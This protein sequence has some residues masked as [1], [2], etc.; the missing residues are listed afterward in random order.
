MDDTSIQSACSPRPAWL[1][2]TVLVVSFIPDLLVSGTAGVRG[3][4]AL[5]A[6]HVAIALIAV[7]VFARVLPLPECASS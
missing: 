5:M 7:P 1:V 6:M 2:P 3:T 4:I